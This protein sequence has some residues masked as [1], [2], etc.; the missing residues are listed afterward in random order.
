MYWCIVMSIQLMSIYMLPFCLSL[1][2]VPRIH[3]DS[4]AAVA[5]VT[6]L[7]QAIC[8]WEIG[9]A[10]CMKDAG[11]WQQLQK[12][13]NHLPYFNICYPSNSFLPSWNEYLHVNYFSFLYISVFELIVAGEHVKLRS[14][15][16]PYQVACLERLD[17]L[18]A[19]P[20]I[21]PSSTSVK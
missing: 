1:A 2:K 12:L 8:S 18:K 17:S 16:L 3:R 7:G 11:K 15:T 5:K 19:T 14:K 9:L 6:W 21:L 13:E 4:F 10:T 20:T